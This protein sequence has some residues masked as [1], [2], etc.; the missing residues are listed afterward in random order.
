MMGTV[1][2]LQASS[3]TICRRS[4]RAPRTQ[5]DAALASTWQ[6]SSTTTAALLTQ[7]HNRTGALDRGLIFSELQAAGTHVLSQLIPLRL[8]RSPHFPNPKWISRRSQP[9]GRYSIPP[10]LF[11]LE[12]IQRAGRNNGRCSSAETECGM[13]GTFGQYSSQ[14]RGCRRRRRPG[15][16]SV[17][18]LQIMTQRVMLS[19]ETLTFGILSPE[20]RSRLGAVG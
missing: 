19:F 2:K 4:P 7:G 8:M 18:P 10:P 11:R 13:G 12:T 20:N 9:P 1:I 5:R 17:R 15:R 16:Q 3:A 14:G 6:T